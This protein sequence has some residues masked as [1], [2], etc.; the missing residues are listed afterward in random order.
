MGHKNLSDEIMPAEQGEFYAYTAEFTPDRPVFVLMKCK[1]NKNRPIEQLSELGSEANMLF[2]FLDF[3]QA[4]VCSVETAKLEGLI[5]LQVDWHPSAETCLGLPDIHIEEFQEVCSRKD[6]AR[7]VAIC[8]SVCS[9]Q[10]RLVDLNEGSIVAVA[11]NDGKYGLFLLEE[12]YSESIRI[13]ACHI[14]L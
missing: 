14:R 6:V 10:G 5:D 3:N 7:L 8:S 1:S 12:I 13:A 2:Q 11:T 9:E 4:S